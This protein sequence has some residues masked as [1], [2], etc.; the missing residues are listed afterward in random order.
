MLD[1]GYQSLDGRDKIGYVTRIKM[2]DINWLLVSEV[3]KNDA[4]KGIYQAATVSLLLLMFTMLLVTYLARLK[5][6][7]F[8]KPIQRLAEF[9]RSIKQKG[10][11]K[12]IE[13]DTN[14]ELSELAD[15]FKEMLKS[16]KENERLL[17]QSQVEALRNYHETLKHKYAL[18]QHSIVSITDRAGVI[19][20]VNDK[21][22]E[23]S[24]FSEAELIG[25]SHKLVNSGSHSKSFFSNMYNTIM[26]GRTWKA[27]I[28]NRT[29]SGS[30]Y[31]VDTT[32]VPYTNEAGV[33]TNFIAVR[34]DITS[35]KLSEMALKQNK[36][37][38]EQVIDGTD[39]GLWDWDLHSDIIDVNEHWA[40]IL[41]YHMDEIRP[42]TSDFWLS[43]LH[44]DDHK[45]G[46]VYLN[47]HWQ[48]QGNKFEYEARMR[49]KVASGFGFIILVA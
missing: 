30:Y 12:E 43:L 22:V 40:D 10:Y 17:E 29:K 7:S 33:I 14:D 34:T 38:L 3:D 49:H 27:A 1:T 24:G 42:V 31:W 35:L 8:I 21:F 41:G 15:A 36:E 2:S 5:A 25:K 18:D 44:P 39:V 28:K 11:V 9:A 6:E 45:K 4:L 20:Y 32:I 23:V 46:L 19:E 26:A 48:S 13:V 47:R 37:Q 16:Q